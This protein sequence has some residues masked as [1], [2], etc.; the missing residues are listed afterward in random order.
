MK[1]LKSIFSVVLALV[2]VI[3]FTSCASNEQK[4]RLTVGYNSSKAIYDSCVTVFNDIEK[5]G[6]ANGYFTDFASEADS[7]TTV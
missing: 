3:C 2:M 5:I 6:K 7:M 4:E 1:N